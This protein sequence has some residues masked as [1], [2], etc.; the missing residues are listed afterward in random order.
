MVNYHYENNY[1]HILMKLI[2]LV[3]MIPNRLEL[4]IVSLPP[5]ATFVDTSLAE[6]FQ[7]VMY[8]KWQ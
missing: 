8:Q 3:N 4:L 6:Y 2:S 1:N 5:D 7:R